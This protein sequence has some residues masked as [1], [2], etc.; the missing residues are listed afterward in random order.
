MDLGKISKLLLVDVEGVGWPREVGAI[1]WDMITNTTRELFIE[2]PKDMRKVFVTPRGKRYIPWKDFDHGAYKDTF[3]KL[4]QLNSIAGECHGIL[5]HNAVHDKQMLDGIDELKDLIDKPWICTM[6]DFQWQNNLSKK[7]SLETLCGTFNVPYTN[8]HH[9]LGDCKLILSC[10]TRSPEPKVLILQAFQEK[11]FNDLD[12]KGYRRW[13]VKDR[14]Y[15]RKAFEL[16]TGLKL[17]VLEPQKITEAISSS[18]NG[19]TAQVP[20]DEEKETEISR[21]D[22]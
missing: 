8:A 11:R 22:T 13:S 7:E 12:R 1:Y 2:I 17:D 3:E 20:N 16:R 19:A 6:R 15:Q 14:L 18:G 21:S 10:I 5:A 4:T 9:A